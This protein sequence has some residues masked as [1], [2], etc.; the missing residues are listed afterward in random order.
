MENTN[1]SQK[2]SIKDVFYNLLATI[3]LYASVISFISLFFAY[4][5]YLY[6]DKLS[7]YYTGILD[8]I[9]LST[10]VL[11][12]V[13]AVFILISWLMSRE[14]K[15][16]PE[17]REALVR[18]VFVYITLFASAIT[19]IVDLAVL[20]YRFY[21]GDLTTRFFLK[22][23][24]VLIVAAAVFAYDLLEI[25]TGKNETKRPKIFAWVSSIVIIVAV[26]SGFFI[27]GSPST[28][29]ARNFDNQRV[30][31]LQSIQS[32]IVYYWQNKNVLPPALNNLKDSISGF[33]P[34]V[35]PQNS[36]AYVYRITGSLSFQLCAN[37]ETVG[38]TQ[39]QDQR[40]AIPYPAMQA[41]DNWNHGAGLT[42]FDRAIDPQLYKNPSPKPL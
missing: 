31:D 29:R 1:I 5:D 21:G 3:T 42:C 23:F 12:V 34:P 38:S 13:F 16:N 15:L 8:Q 11:I 26:V 2:S 19:V 17:K 7:Y 30:T 20:I 18:R 27:V 9:R 33:T 14:F 35:D 10:S 32:Q 28:Q 36:S 37:F 40:I 41:K 24:V 25:K 4:V 6:P 39:Y 22:T